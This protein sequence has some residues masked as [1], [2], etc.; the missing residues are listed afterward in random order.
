MTSWHD[1]ETDT[2]YTLIPR[3]LIRDGTLAPE[4][5]AAEL[6]QELEARDQRLRDLYREYD[7]QEGHLDRV[8]G[9]IQSLRRERTQ[10]PLPKA[11]AETLR[12]AQEL[13]TD[14]VRELNA[15]GD[16]IDEAFEE[17]QALAERIDREFVPVAVASRV[18][19]LHPPKDP[20]STTWTSRFGSASSEGVAA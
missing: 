8:Q 5:G 17:R 4:R 2:T 10:G 6:L 19:D 1:A 20:R 3:S 15:L 11:K 12:E 9:R 14:L 16:T 13:E 18:P 7:S